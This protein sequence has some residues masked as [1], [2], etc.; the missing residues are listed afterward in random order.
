MIFR[1]PRENRICKPGIAPRFARRSDK[2]L[3]QR[4][5]SKCD[6]AIA[7]RLAAKNKFIIRLRFTAAAMRFQSAAPRYA[8]K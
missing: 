7:N 5:E 2:V 8:D 6:D 4:A 3:N 1:M